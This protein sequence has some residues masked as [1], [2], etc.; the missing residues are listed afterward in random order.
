MQ[1]TNSTGNIVRLAIAQA[2][3]MTTMNVNIINTAL[4]GSL[5]ASVEWLATRRLPPFL[6]FYKA[7][8]FWS[9]ILSYSVPLQ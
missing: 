3:S 7:S 5:L 4:V 1:Q 6:P 2:L 9:I 8:R